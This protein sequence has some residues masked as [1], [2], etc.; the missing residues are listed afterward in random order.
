[1]FDSAFEAIIREHNLSPHSSIAPLSDTFL[2]ALVAEVDNEDIR[3]IVLGGSQARGD[4]TPYSDVDLA[5][6]VSDTFRPLRKRFMYRDGYL[7]SVVLKTL[8]DVRRHLTDPYQALWTVPSFR[9]SRVLLDK[10][11]SMAHLKQMV[12]DFTWDPLHTEAI[13]FAGHILIC[14]V[15]FVHKLFGNIWKNN[16]SGAAYTTTRIFDGATMCMALY[17]GVFITTESLHY[18]EVEKAVGLDSLWAHYHRLL[19]GI[20]TSDEDTSSIEARA[21]LALRLYRETATILGSTLSEQRSAV[22]R[23]VLLLIEQAL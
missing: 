20:E 15:E 2:E 4:A 10:D 8:E 21:R 22:I 6:F 9:Q 3:G 13:G 5:C 11:G 1:M 17:H 19:I 14:D 12:E 7:I 23:Q 18:E 16:L